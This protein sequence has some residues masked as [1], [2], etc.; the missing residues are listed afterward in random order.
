[1][2]YKVAAAQIDRSARLARRLRDAGDRVSGGDSPRQ[3]VDATERLV[4]R[5]MMA[6]LTWLEA[7]AADRGSPLRRLAAAEFQLLGNVLGLTPADKASPPA[8][9]VAPSDEPRPAT[10]AATPRRTPA[11]APIRVKLTG[12]KRARR[13]VRVLDW[14]LD[15]TVRASAFEVFFHHAGGDGG[16][17]ISGNLDLTAEGTPELQ[18]ATRKESPSGRWRASVCTEDGVQVGIIEIEL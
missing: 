15:K 17:I 13:A 3:A 6:G 4:F 16:A 5:S 1:M 14:E 7:I 11:A 9:E 10:S 8:D 18:L 12:D 2:G